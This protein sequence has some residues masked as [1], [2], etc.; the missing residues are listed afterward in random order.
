M[1][2][3]LAGCCAVHIVPSIIYLSVLRLNGLLLRVSLLCGK[4][5]NVQQSE[6]GL[7]REIFNCR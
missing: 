4:S 1:T 6:T 5:T 7:Q 3:V 2:G